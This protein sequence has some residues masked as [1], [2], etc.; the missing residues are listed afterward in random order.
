MAPECFALT[1]HFSR[2]MIPFSAVQNRRPVPLRSAAEECTSVFQAHAPPGH[3]RIVVTS[4]QHI[5]LSEVFSA[6][7][8]LKKKTFQTERKRQ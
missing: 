3:E 1:Q 4:A 2:S 5:Q 7:R 6:L 8:H